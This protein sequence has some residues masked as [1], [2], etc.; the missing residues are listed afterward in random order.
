MFFYI[1]DYQ[2]LYADHLHTSVQVTN[3]IIPG[4]KLETY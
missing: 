2:N 1:S 4:Y 3:T